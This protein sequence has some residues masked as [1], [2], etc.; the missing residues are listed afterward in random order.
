MLHYFNARGFSLATLC[1]ALITTDAIYNPENG[2]PIPGV[3]VA[4]TIRVL[5]NVPDCFK[6]GTPL[7][8]CHVRYHWFW[9]FG[10]STEEVRKKE[11]RGWY[12]AGVALDRIMVDAIRSN[13]VAS[14]SV[15]DHAAFARLAGSK[16][17]NR[18]FGENPAGGVSFIVVSRE[19]PRGYAYRIWSGHTAGDNPDTPRKEEGTTGKQII[20]TAD[21]RSAAPWGK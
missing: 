4:D 14:P 12:S 1:L 19:F 5:L 6:N 16:V 8:D 18:I 10:G 17:A 9:W 3:W 21:I 11:A 2:V 20:N 15:L 13:K 7:L